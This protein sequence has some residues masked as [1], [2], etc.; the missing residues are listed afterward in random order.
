MST[1]GAKG[2]FIVFI[3]VEVKLVTRPTT[4]V[5][6][7]RGRNF[8]IHRGNLHSIWILG[9]LHRV[10]AEC[11]CASPLAEAVVLGELGDVLCRGGCIAI[12]QTE[13]VIQGVCLYVNKR[14]NGVVGTQTMVENFACVGIHNIKH[15]CGTTP[16]L[17]V[18][19]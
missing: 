1:H 8:I 5:T 3:H 4:P 2:G 11:G 18:V 13:N 7:H 6:M 17:L 10:I 16:Q 14:N 9:N 19:Y 12:H 15:S